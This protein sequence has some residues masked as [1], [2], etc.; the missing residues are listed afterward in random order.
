MIKFI[1][2]LF[3]SKEN[4]RLANLEIQVANLSNL[5]AQLAEN[6]RAANFSLSA[7]RQET[8]LVIGL[9]KKQ[10]QLVARER[11]IAAFMGDKARSK[12]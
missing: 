2:N 9:K 12:K 6:V 8:K 4:Q 7:L 1:K 11:A 10:A 3:S 5:N